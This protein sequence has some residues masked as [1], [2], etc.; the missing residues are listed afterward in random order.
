VAQITI[1]LPDPVARH[2]R[3]E[4][5]RAKK[6]LS[7]YMTELAVGHSTR[8]EWPDWFFELEGSCEGTLE[9][10]EDPPLDRFS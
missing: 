4:A 3:R 10:P 6:S 7:A 2:L 1:Y 5:R 9:A 8:V